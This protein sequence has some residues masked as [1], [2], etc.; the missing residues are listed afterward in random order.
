MAAS[1][2]LGGVSLYV[3][4]DSGDEPRPRI[5]YVNPITTTQTTYIQ[6]HGKDSPKRELQAYLI[7]NYVSLFNLVDGTAKALVSP[8]GSE[9]TYVIT[10]TKSERVQDFTFCGARV[11]VRVTIDMVKVT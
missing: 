3:F 9:G 5:D 11:T 1:W 7:E 8:W 4:K 2:S 10:D 6:Q